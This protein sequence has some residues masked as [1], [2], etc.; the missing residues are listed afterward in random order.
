MPSPSQRWGADREADAERALRRAGYRIVERNWRGAGAEIDRIA[1]HREV[2]CIVE[3]RARENDACGTPAETIGRSK[4][5]HL[6]RGAMA[7]L[8]Q[9]FAPGTEPVVRFDVVSIVD[10]RRGPTDIEIIEDAF[11]VE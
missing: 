11:V 2:L 1:W 3:I 10:R 6:I 4:Q 5:R 7:Y 8:A 9:R